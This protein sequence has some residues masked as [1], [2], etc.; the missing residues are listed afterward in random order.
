MSKR[1]LTPTETSTTINSENCESE[2]PYNY[3]SDADEQ[4]NLKGLVVDDVEGS[5]SLVKASPS[6]AFASEEN[7][8]NNK[9]ESVET[10]SDDNDDNEDID[11]NEKMQ[12]LDLNKS[13]KLTNKPFAEALT[14]LMIFLNQKTE[15]K[16]DN[17]TFEPKYQTK[18]LYHN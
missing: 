3:D 1:L 11:I 7:E 10:S 13:L 14:D 17:I 2:T 8:L 6:E 9:C 5:P 12:D 18:K 16:K 15:V 4:G